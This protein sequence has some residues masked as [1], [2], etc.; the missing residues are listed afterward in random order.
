[1]L[2]AFTLVDDAHDLSSLRDLATGHKLSRT[3][4]ALMLAGVG[5]ALLTV[6]VVDAVIDLVPTCFAPGGNW[7]TVPIFGNEGWY[8]YGWTV[9]PKDGGKPAS[10]ITQT[11][12]DE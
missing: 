10:Y 9:D 2:V 4:E 1:M 7:S 5:V 8:Y 6:E 11:V 3:E 12:F